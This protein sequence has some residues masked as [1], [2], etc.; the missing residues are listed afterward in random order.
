MSN[1]LE[2]TGTLKHIG[3]TEMLPKGNNEKRIFV[4][5][6]EP[7]NFSQEI[8]FELFKDKCSLINN[9]AEG[10]T[11]TVAFNLRGRE[12]NGKWYTNLSAW[13]ISASNSEPATESD[14]PDPF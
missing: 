10:E 14:I 6:I 12:Y 8:C 5:E 7:G 9:F 1:P 4:V 13:K 2:I 11:I 3:E